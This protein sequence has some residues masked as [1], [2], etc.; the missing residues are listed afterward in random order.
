MN[1]LNNKEINDII[2]NEI[3][4]IQQMFKSYEHLAENPAFR[5]D[6]KIFRKC[7]L[8]IQVVIDNARELA[9][10]NDVVKKET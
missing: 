4:P 3:I 9:N 10:E 7:V 1:S 2:H 5:F 6:P 8:K